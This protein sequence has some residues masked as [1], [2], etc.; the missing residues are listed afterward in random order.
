MPHR[1]EMWKTVRRLLTVGAILGGAYLLVVAP[2]ERTF[3][4]TQRTLE[5]GLEA[6]LGAGGKREVRVVKGRAE[7]TERSE[8][9][10]LA[11]ME[12]RMNTTRTIEKSE[13]RFGVP[14]GTKR[15][16]FRGLYKVK[17]G[18]RLQPGTSLWME[19]KTLVAKFPKAEVLSVELL[20]V[21][22]LNEDSAWLNRV[23][24]GD[25]EQILRELRQQM[26]GEARESGMLDTIEAT[27]KT[28]LKDLMGAE[29]VRMEEMP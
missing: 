9:S 8:I 16:V 15:L 26:I 29:A 20:E 6:I 13:S 10:E 27:M 7:I 18:Y 5:Q 24:K 4:G 14:L 28:R 21:E 11:L 23:A 25:R 1:V 12:M 2:L 17:G 19:G 3:R 22:I